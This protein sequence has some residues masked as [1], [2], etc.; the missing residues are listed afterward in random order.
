M[1]RFFD[2]NPTHGTRALQIWQILICKAS[3]RQTITYGGLAKTLGFRGAGTLAD[4]LGHVS[5]Y[6][7]Q[8]DLPALTVL[9]VNQDTGLPG[10]GLMK[11]GIDL[12]AERE[13]VFQYDWFAVV[14][15]S[16]EE[17]REAF[18]LGMANRSG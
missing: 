14:P 7:L 12:D 11:I 9:V 8:H 3:N 16:P 5:F 1:M 10:E 4:M 17:F 13:A 15:P 6:C 18:K 2:D